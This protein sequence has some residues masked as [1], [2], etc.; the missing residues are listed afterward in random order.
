ME[1][2]RQTLPESEHLK[3]DETGWKCKGDRP[4]SWVF[5]SP[6]VVYFF[7]AANCKLRSEGPQIRFRRN[8]PGDH[9]L[10]RL[11]GLSSVPQEWDPAAVL[12][13]YHS[14]IESPQGWACHPGCLPI[15]EKHAEGS[16]GES[17][18]AGMLSGMASSL[19]SNSK[20]PPL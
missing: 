13:S 15:L 3:I 11:F 12:G 8:F 1:Q 20:M 10:R 18:V 17:S 7:I 5:V 19:A 4:L 2:A 14:K 6:L 16:G 9:H